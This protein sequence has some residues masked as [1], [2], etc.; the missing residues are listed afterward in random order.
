MIRTKIRRA[1]QALR[2]R[3][4]CITAQEYLARRHLQTQLLVRLPYPF[5]SVQEKQK[6]LMPSLPQFPNLL[7]FLQLSPE[8]LIHKNHLSVIFS[9]PPVEVASAF[10]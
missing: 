5:L 10:F 9:L 6:Q 1:Y 8:K 2:V 4:V 7:I 3:L